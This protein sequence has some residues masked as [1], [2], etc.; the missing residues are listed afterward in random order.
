MC[1]VYT[2]SQLPFEQ[3][4][5]IETCGNFETAECQGEN[6][7]W[8]IKKKSSRLPTFNQKFHTCRGLGGFLLQL[9]IF[10]P[11]Q[12]RYCPI[13]LTRFRT[14]LCPILL[15]FVSFEDW[16]DRK[17]VLCPEQEVDSGVLE[18]L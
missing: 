4:T 7:T 14:E 2:T 13:K 11:H 18:V 3:G 1:G 17:G 6:K 10:F 5:I 9:A 8:I 16:H 12:T 15:S